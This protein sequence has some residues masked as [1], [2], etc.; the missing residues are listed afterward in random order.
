MDFS[1]SFVPTAGSVGM[2]PMLTYFFMIVSA[3]AFLANFLFA[4]LSKSSV[5]PE[6][7]VSRYYTAIIAAVAGIS[8]LLISHFFHYALKDVAHTSDQNQRDHIFRNA[9]NAIGQLRYMDWSITT[10]LLLMKMVSMLRIQPHHEKTII[11]VLLLADVFMIVTG[12]VGEQQLDANGNIIVANKLIWGA[13]STI[14]YVIIPILLFQLW[15]KYKDVVHPLEKNA[16]R[17]MA[18]STVTTWGIY[19][20]GYILSTFQSVDVNYIQ[21]GFSIGDVINKVGLGFIAY[22]T[23]KR[24]I[25]ERLPEDSTMKE[26]IVA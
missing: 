8:Y 5:A 10:P 18:L 22:I 7:R 26:H 2:L 1:D 15:K 17:L 12:Y 14:G 13:I 25:E 6:H 9:Y 21:I 24:L 3:Y 11:A 23:A 19:P 4:Y 16:F 20:I